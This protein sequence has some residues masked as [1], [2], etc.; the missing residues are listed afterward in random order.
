LAPDSGAS[1]VLKV[2]DKFGFGSVKTFLLLLDT[3]V[4]WQCF[5]ALWKEY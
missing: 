3:S 4:M 2:I 1:I 5:E